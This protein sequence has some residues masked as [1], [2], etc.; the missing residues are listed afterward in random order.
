MSS[1]L[2]LLLI[3]VS[4]AIAAAWAGWLGNAHVNG[5]AGVTD[6][7]E[8]L[9]LDLRIHFFGHRST[10]P[11]VAIVA[12]DDATVAAKGGYPIDR[13]ELARLVRAIRKAGARGL[14]VDLLLF[15]KANDATDRDLAAAFASLPTIIAGAG[16]FA[17]SDL[18]SGFIPMTSGEL[19]PLPIFAAAATVGLVNISTDA[20]GTPRHMPLVFGTSKGAAPSFALKAAGLYLSSAPSLVEGGVR[21][22]GIV[23][24][25]DLGWHLPLHLYGPRGTIGTVSAISVLDGSSAPDGL[26]D[27][28]VVLGA[29]ATG[30]GDRYSTPFD[31]VMPGV[32]VLASGIANLLDDSGLVRDIQIR[33]IDAGATLALAIAGVLAISFLPVAIGSL[34][35]LAVLLGWLA[36]ITVLFGQGYW[37]AGAL[38]V[39]GSLPPAAI[40][41]LVKQHL[42]RR[43]A[44]RHARG[45]EA[46]SR[47]QAPAMAKLLAKD[48]TFLIIP[49]EQ[50]AAIL[51]VDLSGF[52][53]LS[54][55]Y[56]PAK[57]RN[58]LKEFHTIVV[59]I[60]TSRGGL[61]LD[62][63]GDGAMVGFGIS[64]PVPGDG[65]RALKASFVLAEAVWSWL[66]RSNLQHEIRDV[67]IGIDYGMIVLS[68]LGHEN[69]QQIAA[70]GDCVNV[71]SRLIEIGKERGAWIAAS[72]RL[73]DTVGT[74]ANRLL[75]S[76]AFET[77]V[78]RGRREPMG[79]ALWQPDAVH[80]TAASG[81]S[82]SFSAPGDPS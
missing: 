23:Q 67:R 30:I 55:K 8:L 37:V 29:T 82:I 62:F 51:F 14:A 41:A 35:F 2:P 11:Q 32:E 1:R 46:L 72:S 34:A 50:N 15:D 39:A 56:G 42:D 38:P 20:G 13:A 69:Q 45:H 10:P 36:T 58:I 47:F 80:E 19:L 79:V 64:K 27:R 43:D 75:R 26:K 71:A 59:E 53:G 73:I 6:R 28:L 33:R 76:P 63:M 61:V 5:R 21:I 12:I 18:S 70:T 9:L 7:A 81:L 77:V 54:E 74:A 57:T 60:C 16:Q 66:C 3:A 24:R 25:M 68:R 52:V 65:A 44:E 40:L 78:V 22:D 48:P 17:V 31:P 49:Q 4:L